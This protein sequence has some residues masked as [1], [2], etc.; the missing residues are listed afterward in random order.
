[1]NSPMLTALLALQ[2]LEG[3]PR[4]GWI[5]RGV[6]RPESVADH[7][8][9]ACYVA[10]ALG[11]RVEP[12]IDVERAL[13]LILVHD[14]PEALLGDL[15]RKAASL[16]PPGA[17]ASAEA[18][19]AEEILPPLSDVAHERFLEYRA[20]RSREARF[21]R[22]CDRLQL[23]VKLLAHL[24]AGVRGLEDFEDTLCALDCSEFRPAEEFK[25]EILAAVERTA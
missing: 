3:L 18:R 4:T 21:A 22:L 13:A 14:A 5:Q 24:R 10:L 16:L 17:K 25:R 20:A 1:M 19:A 12:P 2:A 23:G 8:L 7:I 11:P 15:P 9:G 6:A